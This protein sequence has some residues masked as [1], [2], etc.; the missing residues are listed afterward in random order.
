MSESRL[1]EVIPLER[2]PVRQT[3]PL[4]GACSRRVASSNRCTGA[5]SSVAAVRQMNVG[6]LT[7]LLT[8]PV[9]TFREHNVHLSLAF[10]P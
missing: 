9:F 2:P 5:Q 1:A 10:D 6:L 4:R 8:R 7:C 3:V